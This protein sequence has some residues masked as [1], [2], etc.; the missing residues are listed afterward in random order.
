MAYIPWWQRMS[1]PTFAERFEL[2][3]LAGRV[4]FKDNPLK[5]FIRNPVGI[6]QYTKLTPSKTLVEIQAIIDNAPTVEIDGKFFEQ[7]AK[8]LQG[9][10]EYSGKELI[11]RKEHEKY[12]DKLKYKSTGKKRIVSPNQTN[13]KRYET[14]KKVQGSNISMIGSGQTGKQ[15]SHVYPLIEDA[16]P[17]TKTTFVIDAKMNRKLEGFNQIGQKIAEEQSLIKKNNKFPLT[18]N[19]KKQ[20]EVL[21]GRAKLNARNAINTLG[22]NFKGQIGYFQ[23]DTETGIFKNKAGNFKMSFA[24]LKNKDKI[25]KDMSGKERKDFER[26]ESKKLKNKEMKKIVKQIAKKSTKSAAAKLL[27]PAMLVNQLLFG[28]KFS[29]GPWDFPLTITEDVKQTN[30]LLEMIGDK[31]NLAAGGRVS[32][33]DG[34]IASLKK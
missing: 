7:S 30:E 3:G 8:D 13:I 24:G 27:Y 1:P 23:V 29:T 4:G 9:R 10:S 16:P 25:Y 14:I 6:N 15:F 17:G 12:K 33:F 2:G 34:G 28:D 31:M 21:N 11:T 18:G 19:A 5:N 20:M 26:T 32:Y 22:K